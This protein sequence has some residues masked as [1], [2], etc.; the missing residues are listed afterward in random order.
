MFT[1]R[2]TVPFGPDHVFDVA[3]RMSDLGWLRLWCPTRDVDPG[4]R[5][6]PA[7]SVELAD[8]AGVVEPYTLCVTEFSE[9]G[10]RFRLRADEV[11]FDGTLQVLAKPG[12]ATVTW[13]AEHRPPG[14]TL[15]GK[16]GT[17]LVRRLL[18]AAYRD[19]E[20]KLLQAELAGLERRCRALAAGRNRTR[21]LPLTG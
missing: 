21:D 10:R 1:S 2:R 11:G 8:R 9:A 14:G 17:G 4:A 20:T 3:T 15:V 7:V 13:T 12:G 6:G 19:L 5:L 16:V 18:P